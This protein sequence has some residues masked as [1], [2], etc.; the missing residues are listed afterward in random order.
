[1]LTATMAMT[2]A[3][4]KEERASRAFEGRE[5]N[6]A[7]ALYE[8]VIDQHPDSA[9]LYSLAIVSSELSG[10]TVAAPDLMERAMAHGIG[11]E[12][13]LYDVRS[14]SFSVGSGDTYARFLLRL[15]GEMPWM[16]R[17]IDNQL[18]NYYTFR[19]D[20]AQMVRYALVMLEGLSDSPEYLSLLAEGYFLDG[21][22]AM[23]VATWEHILE[24]YP[25]DYQALLNLGNYYLTNGERDRAL[26]YLQRAQSI[27]PTP[28]V[29]RQLNDR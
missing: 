16:S 8:L 24:L 19:R 3:I 10:D 25:G 2:A 1:M 21:Q 11:F 15:R 23:A 12:R 26:P 28:Y 7:A 6:S 27:H 20:G 9:R 22:N 14:I 29:G 13:L 17:P 18:L 5:W 4:S